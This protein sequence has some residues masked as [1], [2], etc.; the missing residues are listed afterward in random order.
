VGSWETGVGSGGRG[1]GGEGE[2]EGEG[3]RKKGIFEFRPAEFVPA[4]SIREYRANFRG[5]HA[6]TLELEI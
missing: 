6:R 4:R 3:K 1:G 5:S 2:G